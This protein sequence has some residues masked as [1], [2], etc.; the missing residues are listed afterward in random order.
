MRRLRSM[1]T[2]SLRSGKVCEVRVAS[3]RDGERDKESGN[4]RNKTIEKCNQFVLQFDWLTAQ[5]ARMSDIKTPWTSFIQKPGLI[6]KLKIVQIQWWYSE[7]CSK[8]AS[9]PT[10]SSDGQ[11]YMGN[12]GN[13][14]K[15][16]P[17]QFPSS[18]RFWNFCLVPEI[19]VI[20]GLN[21]T[22]PKM[23]DFHP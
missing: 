8:I 5:V 21:P 14:Q 3:K 19:L 22:L 20:K 13:N 16:I 2:A 9:T 18:G 12:Q 11:R 15:L 17:I 10:H 7:R 1:L 6:Q 4:G 23:A